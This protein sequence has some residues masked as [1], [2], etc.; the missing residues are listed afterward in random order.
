MAGSMRRFKFKW[1]IGG[2]SGT[3]DDFVGSPFKAKKMGPVVVGVAM[4]LSCLISS[5]VLHK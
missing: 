4:V 2:T 5:Q 1:E 3:S